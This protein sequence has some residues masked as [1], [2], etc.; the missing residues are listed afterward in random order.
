M[1]TADFKKLMS[2]PAWPELLWLLRAHLIAAK[3][4]LDAYDHA[5]LRASAITPSRAAPPPLVTGN[6]LVEAG[7]TPGPEMGSV[8]RRLYREQ[9]NEVLTTRDAALA[10][11]R[12]MLKTAGPPPVDSA[13]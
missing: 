1:E 6:D 5:E 8:L 7:M 11:A 4:P 13:E 2:G 12:E 10:R 3:E 9:L